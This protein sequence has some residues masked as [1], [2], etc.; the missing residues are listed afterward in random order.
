MKRHS[1]FLSLLVATFGTAWV[2]HSAWAQDIDSFV[3]SGQSTEQFRA[4]AATKVMVGASR[5]SEIIGGVRKYRVE[6][7]NNTG[8]G[9]NVTLRTRK[10]GWLG[11]VAHESDV[12][13]RGKTTIIWDGSEDHSR[14]AYSGLRGLDFSQ[15]S[16]LR[17]VVSR[18]QRSGF[19]EVVLYDSRFPNGVEKASGRI[20]LTENLFASSSEPQEAILDLSSM[21]KTS[22]FS[23]T[24]I[25]AIKLILTSDNDD[26]DVA[27]QGFSA[28][29]GESPFGMLSATIDSWS[30]GEAAVRNR[31]CRC[32]Y[33][34][35]FASYTLF[36]EPTEPQRPDIDGQ[37]LCG[38][39]FPRLLP[40]H[41]STQLKVSLPPRC[42]PPLS[43][44]TQ[45]DLVITP[46]KAL[47]NYQ[48]DAFY[49]EL[50][51]DFSQNKRYGK[52]LLKGNPAS[53]P[54]PRGGGL[55]LPLCSLTTPTP[56]ASATPLESPTPR[57]SL[58]PTNTS[59]PA[60]T[61]T[62]TPRV[63]TPSST[64]TS[65]ST[66][67]P[68][69]TATTRAGTP[70]PQIVRPSPTPS[71]APT[72]TH[73]PVPTPLVNATP[74]PQPGSTAIVTIDC[75]G[76]IGGTALVDACGVCEGTAKP[77]EPCTSSPPTPSPTSSPTARQTPLVEKDRCLVVPATPEILSFEKRLTA[78]ARLMSQRFKDDVRRSMSQ[79]CTIDLRASQRVVNDTIK[80]ITSQ[81]KA[82][83]SRGIEVCGSE[84]VTGAY[85]SQVASLLPQ[86]KKLED[87]ILS[88]ANAVKKCLARK[89]RNGSKG[90][91]TAATLQNVKKDLGALLK[92]CAAIKRCPPK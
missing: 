83:F 18:I 47:C 89:P 67:A 68:T 22:Q 55:S 17:L 29:C 81:S 27:L 70:T 48:L 46:V 25:G 51:R 20:S 76:I 43:A 49:G 6:Q 24:T 60:L 54:S 77:G 39:D 85:E 66:I 38:Y 88:T 42:V 91:S 2:R 79:K 62:S 36:S 84:C 37:R 34:V 63:P 58:S 86:F 19:A 64:P 59:T 28:G 45:E 61:P 75:R 72:P 90:P 23:F 44:A 3:P 87:I 21:K 13:T 53:F 1:F 40:P 82:I 5:S 35:G 15:K 41:A 11:E 65:R 78:K 8:A 57:P 30:Q 9:G 7:N 74:S 80:T 4:N 56:G 92:Q 71:V 52:R 10:N 33:K 50:L 26:F 69:P 12:F 73:S 31:S 14:V 32:T 16:F